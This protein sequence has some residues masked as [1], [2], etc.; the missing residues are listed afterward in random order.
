MQRVRV[1]PVIL[2]DASTGITAPNPDTKWIRSAQPRLR[3]APPVDDPFGTWN[4]LRDALHLGRARGQGRRAAEVAR[5]RHHDADRQGNKWRVMSV[6][7]AVLGFDPSALAVGQVIERRHLLV[8]AARDLRREVFGQR[9][10]GENYEIV[11]AD[12]AGEVRRRKV[13]LQHLQDDRRE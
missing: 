10:V 6:T 5:L 8:E 3:W 13:L 9:L 1:E 7:G 4:P 11:A 2:G 12:M